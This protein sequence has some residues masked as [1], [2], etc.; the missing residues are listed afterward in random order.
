MAAAIGTHGTVGVAVLCQHSLTSRA[1]VDASSRSPLEGNKSADALHFNDFPTVAFQNKSVPFKIG[2]AGLAKAR[3]ESLPLNRGRENTE[4]TV[5]P[6]R[7]AGQ[8]WAERRR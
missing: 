5:C 4:S 8:R 1:L 2:A 6:L 7:K 3:G